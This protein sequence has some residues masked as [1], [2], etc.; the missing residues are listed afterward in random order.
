MDDICECVADRMRRWIQEFDGLLES[1]NQQ[2]FIQNG[3]GVVPSPV[4]GTDNP[5]DGFPAMMAALLGGLFLA[6]LFMARPRTQRQIENPQNPR[7]DG[8][9]NDDDDGPPGGDD[10]I[11]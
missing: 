2:Q 9:S 10:L 11:M 7:R 3:N 6:M 1:T 5:N 4:G 8:G